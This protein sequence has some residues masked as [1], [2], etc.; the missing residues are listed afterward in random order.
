[1]EIH[2]NKGTRKFKDINYG[3]VFSAFGIYYIKTEKVTKVTPA[4]VKVPCNAVQMK[5]GSMAHFE[6]TD[7][8]HSVNGHFEVY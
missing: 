7:T 1:M 6:D 3:S 2:D 4:G 8:V 5:D